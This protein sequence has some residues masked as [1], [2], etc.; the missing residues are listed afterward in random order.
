MKYWLYLIIE[1]GCN[2]IGTM[3]VKTIQG[4]SVE[5]IKAELDIICGNNF[6][7]TE[8]PDGCMPWDAIE[9]NISGEISTDTAVLLGE[10]GSDLLVGNQGDDALDGGDDNDFLIGNGGDDVLKGGAGE[11]WIA[12][13]DGNDM[14]L[15]GDNDD[16]VWGETGSDS[17]F[18]GAGND[19]IYGDSYSTT[20]SALD[21]DDFIDG[22]A[23]LILTTVTALRI[24]S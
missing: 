12:G 19:K 11:D 10:E 3:K 4:I 22:G 8:K 13:G 5:E 15:A 7:P 1:N 24:A 17:I 14:I 9:H 21:G 16:T 20:L 2:I 18:G 23:L 6:H